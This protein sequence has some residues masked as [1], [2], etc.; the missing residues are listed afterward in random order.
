M[1]DNKTYYYLKL[2]ENFFDSE[3]MKLLQG[4]K[5]GYLYSDILLKLY[6]ISLSQDG[7]L[8]Y[9]GIIPYTPEMVAT[10]TRHQVGTVE[11]AMDVLEKMGFIEILDNG[12]I[13]MLDIQNFI[14]QSSTEAD[15][16]REYRNLINTEKKRIC[17]N[18]NVSDV[19]QMAGQMSKQK[20]DKSTPEYR[21]QSTEI[22]EESLESREQSTEIFAVSKDTVSRTDVQR[23]VEEWNS[24]AVY[25][26]RP[27]SKLT[28]GT[29]RAKC[30]NARI[31]EYGIDEVLAAIERIKNS[32]FLKGNNK[33]GWMITFDWFVLPNNFPKVH[34][35]Y[36][37]NST[38]QP[39][40][41]G[42]QSHVE[43]FADFAR[44]WAGD[45]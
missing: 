41:G 29:K 39:Q 31:K 32:D 30:L 16:K 10:V 12:A 13:Y 37:E 17:G 8:M 7:R 18:S 36:Y 45:E 44:G 42:S 21:E 9:R 11:K 5:D 43:Q 1:A 3:D 14:G 4:M 27:V 19:G 2:K 15:R 34:D 35:G 33:S 25:G 6:L 23:A 22:R 26:L 40:N 28:S 20:S 38:P 24:L